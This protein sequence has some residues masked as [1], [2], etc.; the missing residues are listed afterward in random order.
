ME[1]VESRLSLKRLSGHTYSCQAEVVPLR[2]LSPIDVKFGMYGPFEPLSAIYETAT[3]AEDQGLDSYWLGD[4]AIA[5]PD[6]DVIEAWSAL[7]AVAVKTERIH[8]GMSVTDPFRRGPGLFA[9]TVVALDHISNGRAIPGIGVGEKV[10]LVPF[11]IS[12]DQASSRMEEFIEFTKRYWTGERIEHRGRFFESSQGVVRPTPVQQPH[13]PIWIAA[14][15]PR[16]LPIVGRVGDGWLPAAK[17]PAMYKED[18]AV[19][20]AEARNAGRNPSSIVPGLFM[21][22][23]VADDRDYCRKVVDDFGCALLV[24][25]RT[26]LARS[27]TSAGSNKLSI[28]NFDA[29]AETFKEWLEAGRRIPEETRQQLINYG[30]P[31]DV[32][33]RIL[34]YVDAGVQHFVIVALDGFTDIARWKETA[35]IVRNTVIPEVTNSVA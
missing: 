28:V 4:R 7:A 8:L 17:S 19:I 22:T 31:E 20:R 30:T 3:F 16:T 27:G 35:T 24:W 11:G 33:A 12:M 23:V 21:Y 32:S 15:S 1:R 14:N 10:N 9:Q 34:E 5:F 29:S 18:L 26:S 6:P 2:R 25:W 13:P